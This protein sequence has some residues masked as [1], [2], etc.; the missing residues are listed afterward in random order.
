MIVCYIIILTCLQKD[1]LMLRCTYNRMN[2]FILYAFF[3]HWLYLPSIMFLGN[4]MFF[5]AISGL[6]MMLTD[7]GAY[8]VLTPV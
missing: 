7:L 4:F 5:Y 2:S 1:H 3:I 8:L 6:Y